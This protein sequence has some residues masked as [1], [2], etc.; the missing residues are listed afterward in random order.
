M[1]QQVGTAG[2]GGAGAG[3]AGR[4][5]PGPLRRLLAREDGTISVEF[6]LWTPIFVALVMLCADVSLTFMRQASLWDVSRDTARIVARHGF[7]R[8]EAERYAAA[9]AR[10]S[11]HVPA[12]SV[13]IDPEA[14]LVTVT[15]ESAMRDLAPFGILGTAL[16]GT[17]EIR[18]VQRLEPI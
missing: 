16:G 1:E 6:A 11:G 15:M 4:S 10:F 7:D 17:V 5:G 12:I 3:A 8:Q 13:E 14:A 9:N 2:S 18:V